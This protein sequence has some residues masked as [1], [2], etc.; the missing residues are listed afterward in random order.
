M[1]FLSPKA[2]E[3]SCSGSYPSVE[4]NLPSHT[5]L[6]LVWPKS[7]GTIR[8]FLDISHSSSRRAHGIRSIQS[9]CL[10]AEERARLLKKCGRQDTYPDGVLICIGAL[11]QQNDPFHNSVMAPDHSIAFVTISSL[12]RFPKSKRSGLVGHRWMIKTC[13]MVVGSILLLLPRQAVLAQSHIKDS[14]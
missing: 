6:Y 3:Q 5:I 9:V 4:V 7:F 2:L 1:K 14:K 8:C 12:V 11:S 13:Q 10:N